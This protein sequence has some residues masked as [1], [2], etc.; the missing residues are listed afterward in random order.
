MAF[1]KGGSFIELTDL[2]HHGPVSH[3]PLP[4]PPHLIPRI[5]SFQSRTRMRLENYPTSLGHCTE[6]VVPSGPF[7]LPS[8]SSELSKHPCSYQS[9]SKYCSLVHLLSKRT[10]YPRKGSVAHTNQ[11]RCG[12]EKVG[13]LHRI[14]YWSRLFFQLLL[15]S[16]PVEAT[17]NLLLIPN[18]TRELSPEQIQVYDDCRTWKNPQYSC[19][20]NHEHRGKRSLNTAWQL[21]TAWEVKT[22]LDTQTEP[23]V[24]PTLHTCLVELWDVQKRSGGG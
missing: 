22:E 13:W 23:G 21:R 24:R 16:P 10:D 8:S 14:R 7:P 9:W 18:K 4:H 19:P 12:F 3:I 11:Y 20:N 6:N 1:N 2:L 17:S 15:Y 5:V